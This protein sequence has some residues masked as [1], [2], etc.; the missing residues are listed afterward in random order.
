MATVVKHA[1]K[2]VM[3]AVVPGVTCDLRNDDFLLFL[4]LLKRKDSKRFSFIYSEYENVP[5]ILSIH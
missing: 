2:A 4:F 1:L 3:E 5:L